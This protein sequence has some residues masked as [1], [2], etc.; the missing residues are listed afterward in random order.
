MSK[1]TAA[2]VSRGAGE[3]DVGLH[4]TRLDALRQD[5][6]IDDVDDAV[7][8]EDIRARHGRVVNVHHAVLR[9]STVIVS[10]L[11]AF[12]DCSFTTSDAITLPATT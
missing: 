5:D 6:C 3:Q 7:G 1:Q 12:A 2:D 10:P 8:C 9:P 11:T 4:M